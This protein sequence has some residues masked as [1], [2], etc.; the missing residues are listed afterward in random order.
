MRAVEGVVGAVALLR[1][2]GCAEAT[3]VFARTEPGSLA[4]RSA[5]AYAGLTR[6]TGDGAQSA[7]E[8]RR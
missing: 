4:S 7:Y 5:L 8:L 2:P 6:T 3:S 1:A